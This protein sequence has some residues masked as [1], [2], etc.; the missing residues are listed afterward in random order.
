MPEVY[1]YVAE[2]RSV[3]QKRKVA[4]GMTDVLTTNFNVPPE[5]VVV[6]F[7]ESPRDA[8]AQSRR[9][10]RQSVARARKARGAGGN[11]RETECPIADNATISESPLFRATE[12]ARR[13]CLRDAQC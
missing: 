1:I 8:A 7:V 9:L 5:V 2:G 12:S 13:S 10:G 11:P 6:Q 4:R 3:E